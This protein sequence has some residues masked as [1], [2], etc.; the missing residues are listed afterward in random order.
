MTKLSILEAEARRVLG[1]RARRGSERL[2]ESL[3]QLCRDHWPDIRGPAP[4]T[5]LARAVWEIPPPLADLFVHLYASQDPR[6]AA[7]LDDFTPA[8][9]LALLVL[10]E[11]E[12]GD[13]EGA[14]AAHEAMMLFES[15]AGREAHTR[16]V[17]GRLRASGQGLASRATHSRQPAVWRA[18]A[19]VAAC[20]G[21]H[22]SPALLEATRVLARAQANPAEFASDRQVQASL[23]ILRDLGVVLHGSDGTRLFYSVR[24]AAQ[25][26]LTVK[27]LAEMLAQIREHEHRIAAA[28][29]SREV[30]VRI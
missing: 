15:P 22:D 7:G 17:L 20:I 26:A 1:R 28:P 16:A 6:L 23:Q 27:R 18:I 10:V 8:Q 3:E 4:P 5:P 13:A 24:G 2:R 21:R 12:R 11:L 30:Q 19:G 9:V 25:E 14:R 29:D